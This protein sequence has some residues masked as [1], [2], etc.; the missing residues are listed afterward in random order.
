MGW[1]D[2]QIKR[3]RDDDNEALDESLKHVSKIIQGKTHYAFI[4]EKDKIK[5]A[6]DEILAYYHI[7]TKEIPDEIKELEDQLEYLCR[8]HGIMYRHVKFDKGWYKCAAGSFIGRL[9]TGEIVALTK[10]KFGFYT[11]FN[12]TTQK[13]V[14]MNKKSEKLLEEDGYAFYKPFPLKKLTIKDLAKY[15]VGCIN[16]STIIYVVILTLC[17]TLVGMLTPKITRLLY[18]DII[19]SKSLQLLL[20]IA[21]FYICTSISM[22]FISSIKSLTMNKI[23]IEMDIS[24]QA[25]T[26]SRV[27]SLPASFFKEYNSGEIMSRASYINSL[28]S[29]LVSTVLSTGLSSLFSLMYIGQIF[30]Y[31]P[32]LVLPSVIITVIT[33]LFSLITSFAQMKLTKKRALTGSKMTGLTYQII[34]GVQKIKLSGSEKRIFSKWLN[35]YGEEAKLDYNPPKFLLFN[36]AISS[37]IFLVGNIVMYSIAIKSGISVAD[38]TAFNASFTSNIKTQKE[39]AGYYNY[40]GWQDKSNTNYFTDYDAYY[41]LKN[42]IKDSAVSLFDPILVIDNRPTY[43]ELSSL[44][45]TNC[46]VDYTNSTTTEYIFGLRYVDLN[47]TLTSGSNFKFENSKLDFSGLNWANEAHKDNDGKDLL[48]S[49]NYFNSSSN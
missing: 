21:V 1:F 18:S 32:E 42:N 12:P 15:I 23:N 43:S 44:K 41:C 39:T 33:L 27:L 4:D 8:P 34:S 2:E 36:G 16:L 19:E 13:R 5:T 29:T 28:C 30:Q 37:T 35:A 48:T 10:N 9:K 11:F 17:T 38:Y 7:K 14:W 6:I 26:M 22:L 20:A 31:G 47:Q 46:T 49:Y 40:Y 25:A 45:F 24:V 3:R